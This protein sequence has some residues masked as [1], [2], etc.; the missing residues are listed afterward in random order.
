MAAG[1]TAALQLQG[2]DHVKI[3]TRGG[4][5]GETGL[6][7]GDRVAKD[8]PR[9]EAY[10]EV[11]ELNATLGLVIAQDEAEL[12]ERQALHA[13]QEDLFTIGARL[14]AADPDRAK[15]KGTI[16]D[17]PVGRVV[18][19]ETWIDELT[20]EL[21]PLDA[22]ILPGGTALAAQLQVARTVCRRAERA[23]VPLV[24]G[25]PELGDVIL[26]YMNRLSDL[27]FTLARAA[28]QRAGASETTWLPQRRTG[29]DEGGGDA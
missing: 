2:E 10:G 8:D 13:L 15:R 1:T 20:A 17:L 27:L 7:G 5:A 18:V 22:F 24:E 3:Y 19:L 4:D 14:A 29:G 28:N 25:Q 26:P 9:V 11:D 21:P 16:P 12:L 6:F 23:I